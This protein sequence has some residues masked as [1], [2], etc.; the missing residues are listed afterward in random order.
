[1]NCSKNVLLQTIELEKKAKMHIADSLR[2]AMEEKDDLIVVL[3]TQVYFKLA[4]L[5]VSKRPRTSH[6]IEIHFAV[7]NRLFLL[8]PS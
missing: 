7:F 1:M 6:Q 3:K 5:T 4:D 8:F 2:V